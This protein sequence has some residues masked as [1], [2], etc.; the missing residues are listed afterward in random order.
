MKLKPSTVTQILELRS[1]FQPISDI[2]Y[3]FSKLNKL[4]PIDFITEEQAQ[5]LIKSYEDLLK[6][7]NLNLKY[8][9]QKN[10]HN[11]LE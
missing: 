7:I 8:E 10:S 9:L 3:A 11:N 4:Y 6:Q 5:E 2:S 1:K